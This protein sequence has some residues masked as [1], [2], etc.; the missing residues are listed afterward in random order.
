MKH[1]YLNVFLV[2]VFLVVAA[3]SAEAQ[4]KRHHRQAPDIEKRVERLTG[5]LDLTAEQSEQLLAVLE[6]S[7]EE[8]EALRAR[9]EEQMKPEFCAIHLNTMEDV[10]AILSPE[11]AAQLEGRLEGW[12]EAMDAQDRR[13]GKRRQL[14]RDCDEAG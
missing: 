4:G 14:L 1:P 8:R 6:A 13:G 5:E 11:Q 10:R 12:A 7:A 2:T 9:Y 3:G